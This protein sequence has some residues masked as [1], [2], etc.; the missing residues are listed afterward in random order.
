MKAILL[1]LLLAIP[2]F[3]AGQT[4]DSLS[5]IKEIDSLTRQLRPLIDQQKMEAALDIVDLIQHRAT[6]AF[7]DQH[8]AIALCLAYRGKIAQKKEQFKEAESW[9][10]KAMAMQEKQYGKV[11]PQYANSLSTLSIIYLSA[12]D[13]VQAEPR[14]METLAIREKLVGK[15]HPDY[16]RVLGTL[17]TLNFQKGFYG[18][19]EL[20]Y[21][22]AMAIFEKTIGPKHPEYA[23]VLGN[24]A[25]VYIETGNYTK[26][27]PLMTDV[28]EII[29]G[30]YGK[31]HPLY[32]KALL[33]LA[34]LF[35]KM[36]DDSQSMA[37]NLEIKA[38]LSTASGMESMDYAL[39]LD[40]LGRNYLDKGDY[41]AAE[42]LVLE[43]ETVCAKITGKKSKEYAWALTNMARLSMAKKDFA[44]AEEYL[45]GAY[46]L[47]KSVLEPSHPNCA[48]ST[49]LLALL[50]QQSNRLAEAGKRF[51]ES[52]AINRINIERAA[53]YSSEAETAWFLRK[54]QQ[55]TAQFYSFAYDHPSP[56]IVAA[57]FDNALFYK[58]FLLNVTMQVKNRVNA[59]TAT[60][61]QFG[62]LRAYR[63]RL[64]EQYSMPIAARDSAG[65]AALEEKA[66]ALEKELARTVVGFGDALRQVGW[67][68]VQ[69]ALKPDETAIE[70]IHFQYQDMQGRSADSIFYTA[71]VLRPGDAAPV[72][73]PLFEER[74]LKQLLKGASGSN[75]RKINALYAAGNNG[76]TSLN[77]LI[78]KQLEPSLQDARKVYCSLSGLLH[79]V[80]L[81]SIS[82]NAAE[83]FGDRRQLVLLG[84]T[85]QLV[86]RDQPAPYNNEALLLGGVRY[87]GDSAPAS[88]NDE[89]ERPSRGLQDL[90]TLPFEAD[91]LTRS[92]VWQFLPGTL[93]E[94]NDLRR[95]LQSSRFRVT[96][97]TG[98]A[99]TEESVK[100][101]GEQNGLHAPRILHFATHGYFFPDR[102]AGSRQGDNAFKTSKNPMLRSGLLLAGAQQTWTSGTTHAGRED[103]VLSAQEISLMNLSGTELVVLSACE[104]GLGDIEG[105]EGIYGLQRAFKIAGAKYI[106]MS[107]WKVNDQTTGEFMQEFYAQWL[108]SKRSI[109]EAFGKAQLNLKKKYPD[110]AFHWA[111]FVLVQ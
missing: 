51:L 15:Q 50:Y 32:A 60:S 38:I 53:G 111:G 100:A 74:V 54:F 93:R 94:V 20:L 89:A 97:D 35:A 33:N 76:Q 73:V 11:S 17:G 98:Y 78:W 77:Q 2:V 57:A 28:K 70:F 102:P 105:N 1:P 10:L 27:E 26:V 79:R 82:L 80:N 39:A 62:I 7:G 55:T 44:Q 56:E 68:E 36:G 58:G 69:A 103:G 34:S 107:L 86:I 109:P 81:N 59:D 6:D 13:I 37:L 72:M 18:K 29:A 14:I 42:P 88:T 43:A 83:T 84:S 106:L 19:A 85:R 99:A 22:E 92:E 9:Y 90:E 65:I 23:F 47:Q 8:P 101:Y 96:L 95:L 31:Q 49:R 25:N 75:Y 64:T 4:A 71:L 52:E 40:N 41:V 21:L 67:Q 87:A 30:A 45:M 66:N 110:E 16:A 61:Q 91:S 63:R 3:M 108:N 5:L 12:G 104:T 46:G 48:Q 24:L